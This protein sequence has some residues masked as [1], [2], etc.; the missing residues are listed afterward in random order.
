[1]TPQNLIFISWHQKAEKRHS[2]SGNT[3]EEDR[4]WKELDTMK[5]IVLSSVSCNANLGKVER[6]VLNFSMIPHHALR[7]C[8]KE[9]RS[10]A[11]VHIYSIMSMHEEAVALSAGKR[12]QKGNIRKA[13]VFL[14]E[15][16]GLLKIEDILPFFSDFALIDDDFKVK[17]KIRPIKSF[18][19]IKSHVAKPNNIGQNNFK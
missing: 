5:M 11:C 12:S 14:K 7:L 9:K 3:R 16:D 4:E 19:M 6:T 2:F 13:I 1:M 15:T 17:R 10:R 18:R 8:L